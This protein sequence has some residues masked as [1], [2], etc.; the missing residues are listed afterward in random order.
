MIGPHECIQLKNTA[1][2]FKN[3]IL[4]CLYDSNEIG[5]AFSISKLTCLFMIKKGSLECSFP[6]FHD[7]KVHVFGKH[8]CKEKRAGA[9][10]VIVTN[11]NSHEHLYWPPTLI[12]IVVNDARRRSN[13]WKS[14]QNIF[15]VILCPYR[16]ILKKILTGWYGTLS[17]PET[18]KSLW[19]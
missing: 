2:M 18:M 15:I 5:D 6:Y 12:N 9:P 10:T 19:S 14:F 11:P 1:S 16:S 13:L 7:W 4:L 3:I 8:I 17:K